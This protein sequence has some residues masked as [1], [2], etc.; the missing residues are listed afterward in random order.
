MMTLKELETTQES[1]LIQVDSW[2]GGGSLF[3]NIPFF[4]I[5]ILFADFQEYKTLVALEDKNSNSALKWDLLSISFGVI[6]LPTNPLCALE[7][8]L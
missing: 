8:L 2:H 7:Q 5:Q 6:L 4:A 3:N 1:A